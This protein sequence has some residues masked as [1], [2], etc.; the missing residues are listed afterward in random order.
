MH[1]GRTPSAANSV[2]PVPLATL[3]MRSSGGGRARRGPMIVLLV[4]C[5]SSLVGSA[6]AEVPARAIQD[7]SFFVEEAYNQEPGVVQHIFS[8][9]TLFSS[10][11]TDVSLSQEWPLFGQRHQFSYSVVYGRTTEEEAFGD[12]RLNYRLQA[13]TEK[14]CVP[15][16]APRFTLVIPTGD[17]TR[18]FGHGR[19]GYEVNL[20]L[21][22]VVSD[23]LTLHWN[24][25]GSVFPAIN[26]RDLWNGN[27]G[28]SAIYA[29]T[30]NFNLMLESVA[31]WE[32]DIDS[33]GKMSQSVKALLS[34]GVRW[35]F[36]FPDAL[37]IV[38]GIGVPFGLTPA[39]SDWG[40]FFYLSFEHP[41][42]RCAP[43]RL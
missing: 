16:L 17:S 7:N 36:N 30:E 25:G 23:R 18:G 1:P 10:G 5:C 9:T 14:D 26:G 32:Q 12:T 37:Q 42:A 13:L 31:D 33:Q 21:S 35:A 6:S 43:S 3:A 20:P 28:G 8:V 22:K 24:A 38:V 15:A 40:I 11:D 39:A 34:P 29:V 41:F 27:L 19:L 2:A 4:I